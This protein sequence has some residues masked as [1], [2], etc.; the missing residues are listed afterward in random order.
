MNPNPFGHDLFAPFMERRSRCHAVEVTP[1]NVDALAQ[2]F[3][4]TSS[5]YKTQVNREGERFE[6]TIW[7]D[8]APVGEE[9]AMIGELT[10]TNGEVLVK[11]FPPYKMDRFEFDAN[12]E[13]D[14]RA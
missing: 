2:Y 3:V 1:K 4:N 10:I 14:G 6:L 7:W 11:G 5:E 8:L 9:P 13:P 12:W